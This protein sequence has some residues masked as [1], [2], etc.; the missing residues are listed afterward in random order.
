MAI[1]KN[2]NQI[3]LTS[4]NNFKVKYNGSWIT[5]G[6]IVEGEL[7]NDESSEEIVL[8]DKSAVEIP[9]VQKVTL[10][11]KLAQM[12]KEILDTIDN[13]CAGTLPGYYYNG[14]SDSKHM[15]FFWPEMKGRRNFSLKMSGKD[16]QAIDLTFSIFSQNANAAVTPNT[17][18]PSDKYATG[19]SPV[20][21]TNP[22]YVVL[23]TAGA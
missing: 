11:I 2:K 21:G 22:F 1:T 7:M 3:K 20:S 5:L 17:D 15:E 10:K 9:T 13:I 14:Y 18:L 6:N 16:H 4:G 23:E 12:S 19:A 8:A